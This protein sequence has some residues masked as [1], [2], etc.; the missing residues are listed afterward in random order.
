MKNGFRMMTR[1]LGL[2]GT[3]D[4]ANMKNLYIFGSLAYDYIMDFPGY[5]KDHILPD[6]IHVLSISFLVNNINKNFGG[7]AGNIAYNLALMNEK[8]YIIS[9]VGNDFDVYREWLKKHK[10][11]CAYLQKSKTLPTASAHIVTDRA[12]NQITA[13]HPGAMQQIMRKSLKS[14][15]KHDSLLLI[16]PGNIE[17][18]IRLGQEAQKLGLPYIFDPGQQLPRFPARALFYLVKT[19]KFFIGND[20]EFAILRKKLH[21]SINQLKSRFQC[22]IIT[23][24][25][26]GSEVYENGRKT[27]IPAVKPRK[28]VDPT[29][30]G[31]AFRSGVLKGLAIGYNMI[32]S[33]KLASIVATYPIEH[34]GTQEHKFTWRKI[35]N[36]FRSINSK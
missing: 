16:S 30:A 23:L 1:G 18:M 15:V 36:R 17:D 21:L 28:I 11:N 22:F 26:R 9:Q 34:Y 6:K 19:A 3:N 24:G 33:A 27:K 35:N 25:E 13:F 29:G 8:P 7:T 5:F 10:I 14:I 20:Y 32:D 2:T 31:D 4:S 12:D